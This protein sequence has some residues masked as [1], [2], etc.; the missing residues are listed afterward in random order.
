VIVLIDAATKLPLAVKVVPI[1]KHETLSLRA[2]VTQARTN[3]A[4]HARL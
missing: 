3:L 4:S 1:Q 2:L